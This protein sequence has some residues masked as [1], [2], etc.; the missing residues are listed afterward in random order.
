MTTPRPRL[1]RTVLPV[2]LVAL[3]MVTAGCAGL[4]FLGGD[5]HPADDGGGPRYDSFDDAQGAPG[6]ELAPDNASLAVALKVLEPADLTASAAG[7]IE[8]AVLLYDPEAT[9]PHSDAEL[10][11]KAARARPEGDHLH[12]ADLVHEDF[13]VYA[14]TLDLDEEG[15]WDVVFGATLADG[16]EAVFRTEAEVGEGPFPPP[17]PDPLSFDSFEEA[18]NA[19]GVLFDPVNTDNLTETETFT[20]DGDVTGA[21]Y[22]NSH[23]FTVGTAEAVDVTMDVTLMP[24]PTGEISDELTFAL[25]DADGNELGTATVTAGSPQRTL[26][27]EVTS[28]GDWSV[29]VSGRG[30]QASYEV[31]VTLRYE[32]TLKLLDPPNPLEALTG[33]RPVVALLFD[34][35]DE[36]PELNATLNLTSFNPAENRTAQGEVQPTATGNGTYTGFTVHAVPGAWDVRINATSDDG[37]TYEYVLGFQV[38][39]PDGG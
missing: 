24:G 23:P 11:V 30:F 18:L 1:P 16:T 27:S 33:K 7:D 21:D 35:G 14:G 26:E 13:G 29:D 20:P 19:S 2:I 15:V 3:S 5:E 9:E 22:S 31:N 25:V 10:T 39:A 17:V 32:L 38:H 37:W 34:A 12:D 6:T 28:I 8:L 4:D 36:V